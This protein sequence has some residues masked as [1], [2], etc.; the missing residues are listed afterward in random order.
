MRETADF[1]SGVTDPGAFEANGLG[2]AWCRKVRL[3]HAAMRFLARHAP[4]ASESPTGRELQDFLLRRSFAPGDPEPIDQSELA[5]VLQT[6]GHLTVRG[7]RTLRI[8]VTPAEAAD[9]L[10][11]WSVVGHLLGIQDELLPRP[12]DGTPI[13]A[14]EERARFLYDT[15][16]AWN[17]DRA[18]VSDSGRLLTATLIVTMREAMLRAVPT[19]ALLQRCVGGA[20]PLRWL[21]RGVVERID[22]VLRDV[23]S[24]APRSFVRLLLGRSAANE[25]GVD[26]APLLHYLGHQLVFLVASRVL[27]R[28]AKPVRIPLQRARTPAEYCRRDAVLLLG[29]RMD[30]FRRLR[31]PPF[32]GA[33]GRPGSSLPARPDLTSE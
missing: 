21:P 7:L 12:D 24:T 31:P 10:F 8:Q 16:D 3:V 13:G 11:L 23:V 20:H 19:L 6:F 15:I 22:R 29:R 33:A 25:L 1:V 5:F 18:G 17:R 9:F 4:P 28:S 14:L 27:S 2:F 26:R 32:G 30:R